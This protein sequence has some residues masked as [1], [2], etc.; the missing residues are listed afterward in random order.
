MVAM[1]LSCVSQYV[2]T[3]NLGCCK[4]SCITLKKKLLEVVIS[5]VD[6]CNPAVRM[7]RCRIFVPLKW[8]CTKIVSVAWV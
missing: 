8:Q 3:C 7:I 5:S 1:V 6:Y 4:T 2:D